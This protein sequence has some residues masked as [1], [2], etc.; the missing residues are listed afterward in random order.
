MVPTKLPISPSGARA[1]RAPGC[2]SGWRAPAV[3]ADGRRE[4]LRRR[5]ARRSAAPREARHQRRGVLPLAQHG[6]AGRARGVVVRPAAHPDAHPCRLP[7]PRSHRR[8]T[9]AGAGAQGAQRGVSARERRGAPGG[10]FQH[11]RHAGDAPR[12]QKPSRQK[13]QRHA[14]RRGGRTWS[15]SAVWRAICSFACSRFVNSPSRAAS[16]RR[17]R[18]NAR[19][20]RRCYALARTV[21]NAACWS[22]CHART[23][24]QVCEPE[25][26]VVSTTRLLH[27]RRDPASASPLLR[28]HPWDDTTGCA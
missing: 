10:E 18:S 3:E 12:A 2:S 6:G 8:S 7:R 28:C 15:E 23:M 13:L 14:A 9:A 21:S 16:R 17:G 4:L 11:A 26:S 5:R 19:G 20:W 22:Q 24:G 1:E 27:P 25:R